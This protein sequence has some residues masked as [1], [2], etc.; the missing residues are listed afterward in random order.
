MRCASC[1]FDNP[2]EM[3]FCGECGTPLQR[4]CPQCGSEHPARFKFCG[5]CGTP[6][7]GQPCG[8]QLSPVDHQRG[9]P[10]A[11]P[12]RL[13]APAVDRPQPEGER[14][15]L[16]VLF[17]DLV[18]S[19]ALATQ[20]DPEELR[21][22]VRAYQRVCAEV[23]QRYEGYVAQYL[24]D[25][26]LVYFGYPQAYEDASQ[27][28]VR[29][30]LGMVEAM[31]PL[32]QRLVQ[33]RGVR[34]AVRVGIH[35]GLVVVG[36]MGGGGRWEQL[37]L[38]DTPNV[39]ARLQDLAAPDTIVISAAMQ[40]LVQ[41]GVA[42][43]D[44][45]A[46]RLKGVATPMQ[47]FRVLGERDTPNALDTTANRSLTRLVDREQEVGLLLQR[48]AQ[49]KD[50]H[51]QVVVLS[52][53]A[54]IGK[55]RLIGVLKEHVAGELHTWVEL[56]GSP[57]H[58]QSP[59][60]PVIAHLHR[61][62]GQRHEEATDEK[63]RTL[64]NM[65]HQCGLSPADVMPLFAPL[66]ALP[67]PAHYPALALAPQRQKQK[68]LEAVL[69]LLL[70]DTE[71][72][73]VV[74]I[75]EDLHWLDPSTLEFLALLMEQAAS[76][77][78]FMLL[79]CRPTFR[80][81]WPPRAH[82]AHLT[83]SRLPRHQAALMIDHVADSKGL[84]AEVRQQLL[85]RTD[86]VPLFVEELTKMILESGLLREADDRY[87]LTGPLPA[88]AIPATLQDSLMARLDRLNAAKTVAQLAAAIGRQ[89]SYE[90][91]WAVWPMDEITLRHGLSQLVDTELL[92]QSGLP[93]Q[94]T[95]LFKHALIQEAAYE[96][97]LRSLR[98]HYHRQIA[99]TLLERFP[100][101]VGTQPELL[102]YHYTEAGQ[103]AQAV[104]YW[105]R[106]GQL[107]I[108]RS[109]NAEAISHLRK[110][111]E[112]LKTLPDTPER[113][114]QELTLQLALGAPLL[115]TKGYE[116]T[117]V[118]QAYTRAQEL[119]Q[120][121]GDLSQ[122][123][124]ALV[125]L[126]R[127]YLGQARMQTT[128]E[129]A[130]QCLTLAQRLDDQALLQEAHAMLGTTLL[131]QGE[132]LS[133]RAHL[134]QG[135]ALYHPHDGGSLA[136]SHSTDPGV[137][138]LTQLSWALWMLGYPEQALTRSRAACALAQE[139]SHLYSLAY[140]LA[141]ASA[142]HIFRREPQ[143][144]QEQAEAAI[145]LAREQGFTRWLGVG[146][147]WRG[148]ALAEQGAVQDGLAQMRQAPPVGLS[149]QPLRLAEVYGKAGQAEA[150]LCELAA[151][152]AVVSQND[153]RRFEA[154]LYRLQGELLLQRAVNP[155]TM[156]ITPRES[157]TATAAEWTDAT[158]ASHLAVEAEACFRRALEVARSQHA[159]SLELRAVVSLSRLWQRQGRREEA[160]KLLKPVYGW[161]TEGFDTLDLQEA[162]ALLEA[163]Q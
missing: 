95:Y 76:T 62:L 151:A 43:L 93:P 7:S 41:S 128:R 137:V 6:L 103:A 98:Q 92:Y 112:V 9:A 142:L 81:P 131:Y 34:L 90:L 5:A 159:K 22:V 154:E 60:Y 37:A 32:N 30:A 120:Q 2:E 82:L 97:L 28:A 18:D 136:F 100:E 29:A 8:P 161:F 124:T 87:E 48:W 71:R 153:E 66:L 111:L 46:H 67:L 68:T 102:A 115:M 54:G 143:R 1:G 117:E 129:L 3:R 69:T 85:A 119:G 27:R 73:P 24:G 51:G 63:L 42:C 65:L 134:E 57:Y 13:T 83:L 94:A 11:Q 150:G 84:P 122:R 160:R 152:L 64:E 158:H 20:L 38:G 146:I 110:G 96:S 53:E 118:A 144:V 88:L 125:G 104:P 123:F 109:A 105:Q 107:A 70:R 91:L 23:I 17:C 155:T 113:T 141:Q 52:G 133:A 149:H 130:E 140:A 56:R 78:L 49:V 79:T 126:W 19:T 89:F 106:A 21:E 16:T 147:A 108:E 116:A 25:G 39:A 55:S 127:F 47:V 162:K 163:L 61:M 33:D 26:L 77:P 35:T 135:L 99:R 139:L 138:C 121:V 14:R 86:G 36:E 74:F 10:E 31:G 148:W 114:H 145:E 45:G 156:H 72:Q 59:L 132:L 80:L 12:P 75:M 58:Q 157:A 15:Q 101:I 50:G 40:R 44:L 4:R